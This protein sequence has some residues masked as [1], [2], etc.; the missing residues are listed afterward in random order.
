MNG[1]ARLAIQFLKIREAHPSKIK[2]TQR[3]L[4]DRKARDS[5]LVYAIPAAVQEAR[6]FQVNQ[7]TMDCAYRQ[8]RAARNL[9]RSKSVRRLAE[10]LQ[11]TQSALQRR[12]VVA[13]FWMIS[14]G[15]RNKR[16]QIT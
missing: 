16:V 13:W 14:H 8:P 9:F 1:F 11:K 15:I 6:I 5:Q 7:K 12:N 10:E 2:L 4:A 3:R